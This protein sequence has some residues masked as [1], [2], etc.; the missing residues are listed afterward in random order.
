M[1][2]YYFRITEKVYNYSQVCSDLSDSELTLSLTSSSS[3]MDF[4][5]AEAPAFL[6]PEYINVK[7]DFRQQ[8]CKK[9]N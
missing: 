6:P 4:F 7:L 9:L 5:T 1:G 3:L 2:N 8:W